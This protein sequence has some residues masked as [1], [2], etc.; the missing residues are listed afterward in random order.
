METVTPRLLISSYGTEAGNPYC[1][2]HLHA[3][4]VLPWF[5]KRYAPENQRRHFHNSLNEIKATFTKET[6]ANK[7]CGEKARDNQ[8]MAQ[9]GVVRTDNTL[10]TRSADG[11]L[12]IGALAHVEHFVRGGSAS[13]RLA[14][15]AILQIGVH[16][17]PTQYK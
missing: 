13:K 5:R 1:Y 14:F 16:S 9:L 17:L 11:D 10:S 15:L 3:Q 6:L 12:A 8:G 7:L 4:H 2:T